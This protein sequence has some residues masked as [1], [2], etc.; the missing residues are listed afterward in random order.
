MKTAFTTKS[1]GALAI[2]SLLLAQSANAGF[3][4]INV[5]VVPRGNPPASGPPAVAWDHLPDGNAFLV[6]TELFDMPEFTDSY[7]VRVSGSTDNNPVLTIRKEITNNTGFAWIGYNIDLDPLDPATFVG[8]PTSDKM[9][10]TGQTAT[11]L[12]F[13]LPMA[14]ADG[15][16]VS[17][18]FDVNVPTTGPFGFT[19]SQSPVLVPEPATILFVGLAVLFIGSVKL[20]RKSLN[21]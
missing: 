12:D 3:V 18:T 7:D 11:S 1:L 5:D 19:L 6:L 14:V 16:T 21:V 2:V 9:T 8:T 15:D 13:G 10:L 20:R 17:F 4:S